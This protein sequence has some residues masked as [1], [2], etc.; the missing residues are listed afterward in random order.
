MKGFPI[1]LYEGEARR[2]V[3]AV[4]GALMGL[5]SELYQT[6]GGF[7][8]V[9]ERGDFED[10]DL[11]LRAQQIGAE[12]WVHVRPGLYHLERQSMRQM[13]DAGLRETI[14][15]MNCVEFNARWDSHLSDNVAQPSGASARC[16]PGRPRIGIRKRDMVPVSKDGVPVAQSNL[17]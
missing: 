6:L 8:A 17:E 12:V 1:A 3:P 10:A 9:Y 14:T 4:T 5:A 15:Y 11:C 2:Q 16:V 7:D 13:G